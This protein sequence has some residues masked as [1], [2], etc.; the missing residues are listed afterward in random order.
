MRRDALISKLK[1]ETRKRVGEA[2]RQVRVRNRYTLDAVANYFDS[3]KG[4]FSKY[5]NGKL[6]FP[7]EWV[8]P[9]C[10]L[11]EVEP[12]SVAE[13]YFGEKRCLN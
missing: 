8:I 2:I 7:V 9:L 13:L 12:L 4:I 11:F 5:E 3:E 6:L 1:T 10:R